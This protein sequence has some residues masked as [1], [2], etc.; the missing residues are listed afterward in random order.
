MEPPLAGSNWERIESH[1]AASSAM[2]F[3]KVKLRSNWERIE[4]GEVGRRDVPP[5][6]LRSNWERI[7]RMSSAMPF[8]DLAEPQQLGKN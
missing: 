3:P 4:R 8:T 7:E 5:L 6:L 2:R 1:S